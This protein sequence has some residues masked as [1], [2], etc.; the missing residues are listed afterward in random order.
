MN[1][2]IKTLVGAV[3]AGV[4]WKMGADAYEAVK[5]KI[6]E[7][8]DKLDKEDKT[9]EDGAAATQTEVVEVTDEEPD[10]QPEEPDEGPK[11]D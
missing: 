1:W 4:G 10:A 8:A 11:E 5:S 2:I 9:S 3:V 6:N 7:Q